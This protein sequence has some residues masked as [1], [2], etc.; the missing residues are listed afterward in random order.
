MIELRYEHR[1]LLLAIVRGLIRSNSTALAQHPRRLGRCPKALA[2]LLR[3][4]LVEV[5]MPLRLRFFPRGE[6]NNGFRHSRLCDV[7]ECAIY[8]VEGSADGALT[9]LLQ[10]L[11]F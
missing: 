3:Q 7:P 1:S 8:V 4:L 11:A 10:V 2:Y 5:N 9:R 6:G